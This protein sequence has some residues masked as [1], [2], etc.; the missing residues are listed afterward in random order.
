MRGKAQAKALT[1]AAA[2]AA[3]AKRTA[4][5]MMDDAAAEVAAA[6]GAEA[7]ARAAPPPPKAARAVPPAPAPPPEPT[8][9]L[10]ALQ[11]TKEKE[12]NKKL[13]EGKQEIGGP[14]AKSGREK[15]ELKEAQKAK[16][17]RRAPQERNQL[18]RMH[19]AGKKRYVLKPFI[20]I[21]TYYHS[22]QSGNPAA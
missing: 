5:A 4:S 2:K 22:T 16:G 20:K 21:A 11:Q 17:G 18:K 9:R 3:V 8:A 6:A 19:N 14:I 7:E 12:D 1:G 15:R 13:Q 10:Q